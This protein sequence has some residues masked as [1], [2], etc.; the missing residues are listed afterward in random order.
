MAS[1]LCNL[2]GDKKDITTQ[3]EHVQK[4]R[5]E[6]STQYKKHATLGDAKEQQLRQEISKL[7]QQ[8]AD[9]KITNQKLANEITILQVTLAKSIEE[10]KQLKLDKT[11][12]T[13][14]NADL[15]QA[16]VDEK[17]EN[18]K[19]KDRIKVLVAENQAKDKKI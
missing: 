5:E 15:A 6:E 14:K 10:I 9:L 13:K 3:F 4:R 12:L 11:D 19:L 2:T 18:A 1:T 8:V 16:N 17:T 7:T